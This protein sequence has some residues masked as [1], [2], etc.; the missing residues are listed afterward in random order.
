VRDQ[1]GPLDRELRWIGGLSGP[2]RDLDV[3]IEHLH[4]LFDELEPDRAGAELI[5]AALERERITQR[6]ALLKAIDS[7]RYR[8]LLERFA[9][10]LSGL[11]AHDDG[12][13]LRRLARQEVDRLRGAYLALGNDPPDEELHAVRIDAKH[14]RYASELAARREGPRLAALAETL[15]DLQDVIGVHQ[16]AVVAERRVRAL[17]SQ[18]SALAAGRIVE[19]ERLRRRE[20]RAQLPGV[21]KRIRR[22]ADQAFS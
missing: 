19:L 14:A 2:I 3:L 9:A 18:D 16:D 15:R 21:W 8:S 13:G 20:A 5:V 12:V 22:A 1:L 4:E 6:E 17:A 10:T 11:S 7:E